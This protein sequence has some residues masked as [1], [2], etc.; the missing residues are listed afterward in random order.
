M[1][2]TT[3]KIAAQWIGDEVEV[4]VT[5][6]EPDGVIVVRLTGSGFEFLS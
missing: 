5:T 2:R 6:T 4:K 1:I 3:E